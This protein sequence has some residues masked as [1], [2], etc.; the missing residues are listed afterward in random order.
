VELS[1][2]VS[3]KL[4]CDKHFTHAF[5]AC[6]NVFKEITLGG[7]NQGNYFKNATACSKRMLKTNVATQL[8]VPDMENLSKPKL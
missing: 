3:L 4:R 5:A 1:P 8:K 6:G 2:N 7:S